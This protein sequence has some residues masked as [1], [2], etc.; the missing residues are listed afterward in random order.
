MIEEQAN[1]GAVMQEFVRRAQKLLVH[2]S[3]DWAG[4]DR[5]V[6][7]NAT[8]H[9]IHSV[10]LFQVE[11]IFHMQPLHWKDTPDFARRTQ[12]RWDMMATAWAY[13]VNGLKRDL[14]TT[15]EYTALAE[16]TPERFRRLHKVSCLE[17]L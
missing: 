14:D 6:H 5:N 16:L 7:K 1:L 13:A 15:P 2:Q 8:M 10:I 4:K 3:I 17:L 12:V 11:K 9:I